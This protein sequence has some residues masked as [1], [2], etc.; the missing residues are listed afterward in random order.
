MAEPNRKKSKSLRGIPLRVRQ[1]TPDNSLTFMTTH[2]TDPGL[3]DLTEFS[4]GA[5][6]P[7]DA[8]NIKRWGG[9][10]SGRPTLAREFAPAFR[11]IYGGAPAKHVRELVKNLRAFWRI[12]DECDVTPGLGPVV[13]VTD[14]NELHDAIQMRKG[15]SRHVTSDFVRLADHARAQRGLPPLYWSQRERGTAAVRELLETRQVR[16]IYNALKS[17]VRKIYERWELNN[18]VVPSK[19]DA[20]NIFL[21]VLVKTGWNEATALYIDV[22]DFMRPHPIDPARHVFRSIKV[23]AGGTEQVH[24]GRNREEWAPGNLVK[25][26]MQRSRPL[27]DRL[28]AELA[29]LE[30]STTDIQPSN[31][32]VQQAADLRRSIRS[33]WLYATRRGISDIK[34]YS[35]EAHGW[36]IARLGQGANGLGNDDNGRI[37]SVVSEANSNLPKELTIGHFLLT[38]LR[39]SFIGF[40]Y[41]KSGYQWLMAKLA[42]GHTS[43]ESAISY[44]RKRRFK[45]HGEGQV[46]T[47]GNVLF[48]EIK[49]LRIVDPAILFARVQR[50]EISEEQRQRW[51]AGKDRTR[52]GTGCADFRHPPAEI[53]PEHLEGTGCRVQR[54]TLCRHAIV[55][56]DSVNA[57]C[58][59]A[60]ELAHLQ[61]TMPIPVWFSSDFADEHQTLSTTLE[62][63]DAADVGRHTQFWATEIVCGRHR[64]ILFEGAYAN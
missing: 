51:A 18:D 32:Q 36:R 6:G 45:Q 16:A 10:F 27:R 41:E 64:P 7:R 44:L 22:D 26:L 30:E 23:R 46:R 1:S 60:A 54:C 58:R 35:E 24:L 52:L 17:R 49:S 3:V 62:Q 53:S 55:F 42:A 12:L 56:S 28:R 2:A 47:L 31:S 63:F 40:H 43:I 37:A 9:N 34:D 14:L 29:G 33:P 21:L 61:T 39:D 25:T 48:D 4:E 5:N 19:S 15:V 59:R 13:S 8:R 20:V 57:L 38:D 50:G 11:S